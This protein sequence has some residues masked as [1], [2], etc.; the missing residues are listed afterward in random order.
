MQKKLHWNK[1]HYGT[2]QVRPV[3]VEEY[4][5]ITVVTVYVYYF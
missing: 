1:K 5:A 3:F 4:D 2:K